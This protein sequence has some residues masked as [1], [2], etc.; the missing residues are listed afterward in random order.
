MSTRGFWVTRS[1]GAG[2]IDAVVRRRRASL[3]AVSLLEPCSRVLVLAARPPF[4]ASLFA[5]LGLALS[6]PLRIWRL[7]ESPARKPFHHDVLVGAAELMEGRQQV[8]LSFRAKRSRLLIDEDGPIHVARRHEG[9]VQSLIPEISD[10]RL[11]I[12]DSFQIST[13]PTRRGRDAPTSNSR[14]RRQS[15]KRVRR[16]PSRGDPD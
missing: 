7:P 5:E 9:I 3:L 8:F 16:P 13:M 6:L 10:F 11:Q 2:S 1:G 4:R 14:D 12:S 15:V